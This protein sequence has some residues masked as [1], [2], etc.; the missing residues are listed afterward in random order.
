MVNRMKWRRLLTILVVTTAA[1]LLEIA[2]GASSV[3]IQMAKADVCALARV[4]P[5]SAALAGIQPDRHHILV[6]SFTWNERFGRFTGYWSLRRW[7]PLCC[8]H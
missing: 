8:V 4:N 7:E 2:I 6:L 5:N 3:V 1:M